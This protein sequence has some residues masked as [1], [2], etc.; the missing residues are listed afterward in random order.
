MII[1]RFCEGDDCEQNK[2]GLWGWK[3]KK[4]VSN[5]INGLKY[6]TLGCLTQGIDRC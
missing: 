6:R 3:K 1:A 5:K 4:F 2:L